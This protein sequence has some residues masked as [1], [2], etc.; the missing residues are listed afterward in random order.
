MTKTKP[1]PVGPTYAVLN[2]LREDRWYTLHE[3]RRDVFHGALD[4]TPGMR[5]KLQTTSV[6]LALVKSMV[7]SGLIELRDGWGAGQTAGIRVK[8]GVKA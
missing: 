5:V 6:M 8:Q 1:L 3:I 2:H 7:R 4:H